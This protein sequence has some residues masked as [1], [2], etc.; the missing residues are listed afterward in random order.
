MQVSWKRRK[1][2]DI[3][4]IPG[5][6][7][8]VQSLEIYAFIASGKAIYGHIKSEYTRRGLTGFRELSDD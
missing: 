6:F 3:F 5:S 4:L 2:F 1:N 7:L 8:T